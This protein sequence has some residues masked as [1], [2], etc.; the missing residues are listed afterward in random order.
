M[1]KSRSNEKNITAK[2][3]K[4]SVTNKFIVIKV[5]KKLSNY[6]RECKWCE[7]YG[8]V[9]YGH[10]SAHFSWCDDCWLLL[11]AC[12]ITSLYP[13]HFSFEG[14]ATVS[15]QQ[16]KLPTFEELP[17]EAEQLWSKAATA[18]SVLL[19]NCQLNFTHTTSQIL[20]Q[21]C[22]CSLIIHFIH[23]IHQTYLLINL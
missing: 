22:C 7:E 1:I 21:T 6:R 9:A 2:K 8:R 14:E 17:S 13:T 19:F 4:I 23:L 15:K 5:P 11:P 10:L 20:L 3:I 16:E 18:I 12:I